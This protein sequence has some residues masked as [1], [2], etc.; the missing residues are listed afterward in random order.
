MAELSGRV[1]VITGGS[2]GIGAAVARSLVA[3]GAKVVLGARRAERLHEVVDELGDAARAVTA[4][5]RE[6]EDLQRLVD[7]AVDDF[8]RLDILVANAGIGMYGGILDNSDAELKEML[9]TNVAGTV[10][11][12]RA[13]LPRL[14]ESDAADVIIVSSVAGL[15]AQANEGVYGAT[16]HAQIGL[17][18]SLDRELHGDGIRVTAICPGGTATDFAMGKGRAPGDPALAEMMKAE[19]VAGAI[20]SVLVQPRRMRTLVYSM[21]GITEDD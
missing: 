10:W 9:D 4:D 18:G 13:A 14:R 8:G 19:D 12:V 1:A 16:K 15:R 20:H 6:P 21:R 7:T 17:A 3:S 11:A 5:V 2:S